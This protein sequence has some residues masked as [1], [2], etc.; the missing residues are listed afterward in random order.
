MCIKKS[1]INSHW[2]IH[3]LCSAPVLQIPVF[4]QLAKSISDTVSVLCL[5]QILYLFTQT[6]DIWGIVFISTLISVI[7]Y[8]L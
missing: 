3:E 7:I 4:G 5:T 6:I 8:F 2:A 1:L